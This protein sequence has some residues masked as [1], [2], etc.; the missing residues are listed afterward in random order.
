MSIQGAL[1]RRDGKGDAA[2]A[3]AL[4]LTPE[5]SAAAG[6]IGP[7]AAASSII[8]PSTDGIEFTAMLTADGAAANA[9]IPGGALDTDPTFSLL[10]HDEP[11]GSGRSGSGVIRTHD[12]SGAY[13]SAWA[14]DRQTL[15]V[16]ESADLAT[17]FDPVYQW[18]ETTG[19]YFQSTMS[20]DRLCSADLASVGALRHGN[21]GTA[22]RWFL[23]GEQVDFGRAWARLVTGPHAGEAWELPR[24]GRMTFANVLA[25]PHGGEKT[26]VALFDEGGIETE[27]PSAPPAELFIYIGSKQAEGNEIERAGLTNG[28]LY[29]VRVHCGQ[30]LVREEHIEFG[31]GNASTG[32]IGHGR[33]DLVRLGTA[34]DVSQCSATDLRHDATAADAFRI[35]RLEDGAW[36]PRGDGND[37]L[38]FVTS[39]GI[40]GARISRLWC[41]RFDDVEHPERGGRIDVLLANPPGRIFDTISI[42]KLGRILVPEVAGRDAGV[43]RIRACRIEHGVLVEVDHD[44]DLFQPG[45]DP[46]RFITEVEDSSDLIDAQHIFGQGWFLLDARAHKHDDLEPNQNGRLLAM[47]VRP[48]F[49]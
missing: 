15:R 23:A 14:V 40:G 49:R 8:L 12:R 45:A 3:G 34:D 46:A 13:V 9:N 7:T 41:L 17:S 11:S 20:W 28:R 26:I 37:A 47:H 4:L 21:R 42:D 16:V 32:Y 18:N 1:S 19:Q 25:C 39:A 29:G 10:A 6:D 38:Y 24:L 43:S 2:S 33:F 31:L 35:L 22:E 30:A 36:D 48:W 27:A 44:R 5:R